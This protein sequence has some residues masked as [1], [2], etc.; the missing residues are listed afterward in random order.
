MADTSAS[1]EILLSAAVTTWLLLQVRRE[2]GAGLAPL[3][4]GTGSHQ[5]SD[6]GFVVAENFFEDV[7]IVLPKRRCR[8]PD[9]GRSA[10]EFRARTFDR[11]F[12][13]AGM[14]E[15]HEMAA[16]RKLRIGVRVG[17]VLHLV[18]RNAVRLKA[19]FDRAS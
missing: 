9:S 4:E 1:S 18:R 19:G 10:R 6:S 3:T 11:E 8:P 5:F 7:L 15:C 14:I 17:A 16:M 13:E 2:S 12:A